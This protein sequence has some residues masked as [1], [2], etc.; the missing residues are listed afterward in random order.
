MIEGLSRLILDAKENG[1]FIGIKVTR[2]LFITHL[3]YVYNV[4]I[5]GDGDLVGW[6]HLKDIIDIFLWGIRYETHLPQI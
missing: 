6:K 2:T 3:L 1:I 4:L 5:F